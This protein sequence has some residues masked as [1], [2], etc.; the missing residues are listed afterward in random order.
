MA[1]SATV[2]YRRERWT[3]SATLHTPPTGITAVFG[4]SGCGKTTLL[5]VLAGLERGGAHTDIRFGTDCWQD[6][7]RWVPPERRGIGYVFQDA[8]LFPHLRVIDNLRF[9]GRRRFDAD[10]PD[11]EQV[12]HWLQIDELAQRWPAE[13]S[14]GEQQRVA[15]ARAL[16][17]APRLL[18]LDEPL[19]GLDLDSRQSVMGLLESLHRRV[20][21]PIIYVSHHLEE[22]MRLADRV[23]LMRDGR[24]QHVGGIEQLS[25]ALDSPLSRQ[26][27]AGA[28]LAGVIAEQD[29]EFGLSAVDIGDNMRLLLGATPTPVGTPVR[30]RIPA[31]SVSLSRS[32]AADSSI[33]NIL[34]VRIEDWQEQNTTHAMLRLALGRHFLLALITRRSMAHL[35]LQRGETLYAQI[36]GVALLSDFTNA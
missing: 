3:L 8:R 17:R 30:L 10:G 18:L 7:H 28:V 26:P 29:H 19:T 2:T 4:P 36:K 33:L 34:P 24:V 5:R 21:L 20:A 31:H 22:V 15:I 23:V 14:G 11:L 1:L 12:S 27:G 16:I 9:A 32:R 6:P 35:A 25:T 13:L